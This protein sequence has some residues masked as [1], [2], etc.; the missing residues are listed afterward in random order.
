MKKT[1]PLGYDRR[2]YHC[3]N[4]S[5]KTENLFGDKVKF[6]L[7]LLI[8]FFCPLYLGAVDIALTIDDY[9]MDDGVIFS[10]HERTKKFIEICDRHSCKAAFFCIGSSCV[11]ESG[12]SLL[13]CL[14][15]NGHFLCN[16]SMNH[17]HL[18]SQTLDEFEEEIKLVD[19]ILSPYRNMRKWYR[20]PFLD[21][22]NRSPLGG[23]YSKTLQSLQIL[24]ELGYTEG[25]VTI[26]TFD[27]HIDSRL[28]EAIRNGKSVDYEALKA[29]YI[30]LIKS[31]CEYYIEFYK[32]EISVEI[33][34]T[35]LLHA[36]DLNALFMEEI[37]DMINQSGWKIVSPENAFSNINWRT[38]ILKNPEIVTKKP[39]SLDCQEIDKLLTQS[40]V[41]SN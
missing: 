25:F 12:A 28:A 23:S 29:V 39:A 1:S 9:P 7:K 35:L 2:T 33:T 4:A 8:I 30:Q 41:F 14:D 10:S 6:F 26:N 5:C 16:H 32:N 37:I 27:W 31:W 15:D 17:L 13:S 20:Y 24:N 40:K 34:H 36:N 21:Y 3:W 19:E 38:Q 18:S 11:K 22:G